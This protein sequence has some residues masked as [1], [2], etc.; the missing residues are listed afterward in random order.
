[1]FLRI[2]L[3]HRDTQRR[4]KSQSQKIRSQIRK[5]YLMKERIK[6]PM[7]RFLMPLLG[8]LR[9]SSRPCF[10]VVRHDSLRAPCPH[11]DDS[12][13]GQGLNGFMFDFNDGGD[14]RRD[15]HYLLPHPTSSEMSPQQEAFL[16]STG[17]YQLPAED[18]CS[19]L[20]RCY[21]RNVHQ[22][23]PIIDA[24]ML[25]QRYHQ[26]GC[27]SISLLLLWSIFFASSN[28]RLKIYS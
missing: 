8:L 17:A 26:N 27:G 24:Q 14:V 1:M 3:R 12:G 9:R 25:L 5:V 7:F 4:M 18:I 20:L 16:K 28:V 2:L 19:S 21:F 6:M 22:L 10:I 15:T 23:L 11:I 13:G